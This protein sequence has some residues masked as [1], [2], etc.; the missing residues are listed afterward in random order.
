MPTTLPGISITE[1]TRLL[2]IQDKIIKSFPEVETVFGKAGRA[3]TSTDPAPFSMMETVIMLKPQKEWS[4]KERWYSG[5]MPEFLKGPFRL[6]WP[7]IISYEELINKMDSRLKFPGVIN[8]WTLPIKARIDM[9]TTGV[10]TPVG[11][12]I[13]GDD[14]SEIEKLGNEIELKLKKV[15]GTRSVFAEKTAGGYFL[16]IDIKRNEAS[17]YGLNIEDVQMILSEAVGGEN[18]SNTF[19]GRKRFPINIRYPRDF[20]DDVEKIKNIYIPVNTMKGSDSG[21]S[22]ENNS[23]AMNSGGDFSD[24]ASSSK[25]IPLSLIADVKIETGPGMIRDENGRLAGYVFIDVE[26]RD[27]GGYVNEAKSVIKNSIKLPAGYTYAFSGQ[28]ESME[29]VGKRMLLVLPLTLFLIIVL[30]YI[31]TGSIIKTVIVLLALPFSM[32]GVIWILFLLGYNLSLGVWSGIIALLGI[33]AQTGVLMLL[34]I[35]LSYE[36]MK[37]KGKMKT[38]DDLIKSIYRGAAD[39]IRPRIMAFLT[40]AIGLIPIMTAQSYEIGAD[41]MKRIAAPV[42]GGVVTSFLMGLI[43]YPPI[44]YMW[45]WHFEMKKTIII[46]KRGDNR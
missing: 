32:V 1:A 34:Y 5:I 4:K 15:R 10:R 17:R 22:N 37:K 20:R 40:T 31:S 13:Y 19:E 25:W 36:E 18:I 8:A 44:Y 29:R 46:K 28:F 38:R 12:K 7:D 39:R 35:D 14:L 30:I 2:Q 9:L 43:V 16:N 11:I 3:E 41:M 27:I 33:G 26:N 6:F 45:K 23:S 21:S 42:V 24:S